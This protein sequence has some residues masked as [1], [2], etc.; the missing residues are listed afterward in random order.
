MHHLKRSEKKQIYTISCSCT[1]GFS[2]VFLPVKKHLIF[3]QLHALKHNNSAL[4]NMQDEGS[5][6]TSCC[7]MTWLKIPANLLPKQEPQH[8]QENS[9]DNSSNPSIFRGS[10]CQQNRLF[11]SYF[12]NRQHLTSLQE[13]NN[14]LK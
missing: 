14:S 10:L 7:T 8:Q 5:V 1:A 9:N 2:W 11:D 4:R 13:Y 12:I 6:C 3:L